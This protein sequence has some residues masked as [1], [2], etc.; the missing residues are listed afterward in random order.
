MIEDF[1]V[2]Q[3]LGKTFNSVLERLLV[4]EI[5]FSDKSVNDTVNDIP[6]KHEKREKK[7]TKPLDNQM[8][9]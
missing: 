1:E 8:V 6:Q 4:I 9:C 3:F 5:M 7:K 2:C